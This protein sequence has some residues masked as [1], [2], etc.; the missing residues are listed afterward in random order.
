[1]IFYIEYFNRQFFYSSINYLIQHKIIGMRIVIYCMFLLCFCS[2]DEKEN[3]V[4]I[5]GTFYNHINK[6]A[7]NG[8]EVQFFNTMSGVTNNYLG[9]TVINSNGEF[10]FEYEINPLLFGPYL[11]MGFDTFFIASSKLEFLPLSESWN[12][13]FNISDTASV[14][15]KLSNDLMNGDT[16]YLSTIYESRII[17][18]PTI[19]KN[20]GIIKLLNSSRAIYYKTNKIKAEEI[21]KTNLT[22]NP[23]VDTITLDI[24]P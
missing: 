15:I 17:V 22:G 9:S 20:A 18:G 6:N 13:N 7:L 24:K 19:N 11:R 5:S 10:S 14:F 12:K 16:I 1:M 8:K 3:I 21:A 4:K 2:C 23:I